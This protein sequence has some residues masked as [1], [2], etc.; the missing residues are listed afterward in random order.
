MGIHSS[1]TVLWLTPYDPDVKIAAT[2]YE[3]TEC[4]GYSSVI[5]INEG[6]IGSGNTYHNI[7]ESLVT[8]PVYPEIGI[9]SVLLPRGEDYFLR[10]WEHTWFGG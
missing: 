6:K 8:T 7:H 3:N 10:T 4:H 5:W 1:H 2:V 9:G